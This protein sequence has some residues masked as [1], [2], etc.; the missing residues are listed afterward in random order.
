LKASSSRF[1]EISGDSRD[2]FLNSIKKK[3]KLKR[4][5]DINILP[6][7]AATPGKVAPLHNLDKK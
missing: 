1:P 2:K 4:E 3:K 6:A 7:A 5:S